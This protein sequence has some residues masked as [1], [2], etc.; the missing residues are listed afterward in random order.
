MICPQ[1]NWVEIPNATL[2]ISVGVVK[3]W[4]LLAKDTSSTVSMEFFVKDLSVY[5][6]IIPLIKFEHRK[7]NN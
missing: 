4:T 1:H 3:G 2:M 5:T 7:F 6:G